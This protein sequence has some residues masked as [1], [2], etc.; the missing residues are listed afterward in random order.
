[1]LG[2][3][4]H[5]PFCSSIC[6]Y[7]NFNRGLFDAAL[8]ARYVAALEREIRGAAARRAGR[9]DLLRRRHAV[10]AR[11]RRDRPTHRRVPRHASTVE[12]G[13]RDHAR[14]QSRDR[15]PRDGWNGFRAAGVNRVSFGVQS[16][17]DAELQRLGR[18]HSAERARA[19]RSAKRG[20]PGFDN[21]SLDL[22][23]WLPRADASSDW[24]ESVEAL[25]DV[26]P[27]A[28]V[29]LSA[30]ALSER[31]A[32]RRHGAGGLVAGADDDAAEMYLW[33]LE[34]LDAAG[35][36][37]IRDLQR[38]A[39]RLPSRATTSSTGRTGSGWDSA[40]ARTRPRDGVRWKNVVRDGGL[41]RRGCA[42]ARPWR[43]SGASCRRA[44]GSRRRSSPGCGLQRAWTWPAVGRR[45]G[46]DAWGRFGPALAAVHR[47]RASC[48][49]RRPAAPDPRRHADG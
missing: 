47:R 40:A 16:F 23:M 11:A 27:G 25:I 2:L 26:E 5:I 32:E 9:H 14:D 7:C 45:Y 20:P 1:M 4:L 30:R 29:A 19:T 18:M 24:Q 38:R 13:R 22:M 21:V 15:R 46:M 44:S 10:A 31:A 36:R 43:S 34:R 12:P 41:H 35:Y 48:A 39:A 28:R 49:G 17:Q 8:K 3:Y 42:A 37:A 33:S 6:N